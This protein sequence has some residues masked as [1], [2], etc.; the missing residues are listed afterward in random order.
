M[1]GLKLSAMLVIAIVSISFASIFIVLANAPGPVTAFWRLV[2]SILIL[3]AIKPSFKFKPKFLIYPAIA[4]FAL[5]IH[6]ASWMESLLHTPVAIGTTIVCTHAVFSAIF[7]KFLKESVEFRQVIGIIIAIYG[8]YL[9]SGAE[10]CKNCTE[11]VGIILA[12]IGAIFGGVYFTIGRVV[13][14]KIELKDYMLLTYFFAA[15]T[16]LVLVISMKLNLFNYKLQTWMFFLLLAIV[17]ML[18]GHTLLN[19]TLRYVKVVPVTASVLGEIV[20]A[21]LLAYLILNQSLLLRDCIYIA[22]I[23]FGIAL[24]VKG[25]LTSES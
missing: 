4:G 5:G 2:F 12:L 10:N 9:L 3:L 8:I 13:R 21:T 22:V 20:G 23:V 18:V 11:F 1:Q 16:T 14:D 25:K 24:A 7:S 15:I 6:F 17:P 19:Y